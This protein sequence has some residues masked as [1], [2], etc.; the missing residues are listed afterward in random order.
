MGGGFGLLPF[1]FIL[2]AFAGPSQPIERKRFRCRETEMLSRW[3][4]SCSLDVRL[5]CVEAE[6]VAGLHPCGVERA[7]PTFGSEGAGSDEKLGHA[8]ILHR[9]GIRRSFRN[10][11]VS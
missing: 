1:C 2:R 6:E 10:D 3:L 5:C 8:G 9:P 4:L 7:E 11:I